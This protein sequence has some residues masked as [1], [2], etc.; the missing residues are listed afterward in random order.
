MFRFYFDGNEVQDPLNWDDFEENIVRDE[1]IKGLLPR[2]DIKLSFNAGGYAYLY[3]IKKL[4]G[5]CNLVSLRV[6]FKCGDNYETILNGYI[7]ISD[8]K[9]NRNKCIVEC[10]VVDDNYGARIYNN[11]NI[12]T[13]LIAGKSKNAVDITPASEWDI[14]FFKPIDGTT[15]ATTRKGVFVYDAFRYLIDFMTDGLVGFESTYL[16]YTTNPT[17]ESTARNLAVFLGEEIRVPSQDK[18]A[19][20]S[21][22]DLFKEVDKKFPLGFTIIKG[23]DGRPTVKIEEA[24]YFFNTGNSI[25]INDI[26]DLEESF[27]NEVL[28]S[29]VIFGSQ[30]VDYNAS[31]HS[32]Q[33]VQFLGFTEEEYYLVGECNIDKA[34]DLKSEYLIDT[35]IIEELVFTNTSND[36]YD[37]DTFFVECRYYDAT[38]VQ[39]LPYANITS[40]VVTP[41][42]Y[43][44]SL[45]NNKVGERYSLQGNIAQYLGGNDVG[46][47]ASTTFSQLVANHTNAPSATPVAVQSTTNK[48]IFNNDSTLPNYD[49]AGQYST[50]NYRYTSSQNGSYLFKTRIQIDAQ[51]PTNVGL[52]YNRSWRITVAFRRYNSANTLL[53]DNLYYFPSQTGLY[54]NLGL[55]TF[56]NDP[57]HLLF[58]ASGDYAEIWLTL[59][60][61]PTNFQLASNGQ[62]YF[63]GEFYTEATVTG[64]GIYE[65][66]DPK[67]YF[68]SKL[69]FNRPLSYEAYKTLKLDLSKSMIVNHDGQTNSTAW[70]R[71]IDRKLSTGETKFELISN[72]NNS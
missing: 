50:V 31:I 1:T 11:K 32:F 66:S 46:F 22:N 12:K 52:D 35:N 51:T 17:G 8:C 24:S 49:A 44:G 70:I 15:L 55:G 20:I 58:L 18:S 37:K 33:P 34:L 42:F 40:N 64:G 62:Y 39:A 59:E 9:F 69:E 16:T 65:E 68:V 7:P 23:S 72:L 6:D 4:N 25:T 56:V 30:S 29:K 36:S 13:D 14:D 54:Q 57:S 5:F 67:E 61:Q 3:G 71:K 48:A 45:V 28:Y 26:T 60:S 19:K 38:T 63:A 47:R 27:D 53:E 43:N 10:Q 2:Y 41:S 21:F